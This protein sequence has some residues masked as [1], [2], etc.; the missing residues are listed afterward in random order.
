M[1]SGCWV[2]TDSSC[3]II[4]QQ[5]YNDRRLVFGCPAPVPGDSFP[6]VGSASANADKRGPRG[7]GKAFGGYICVSIILTC[8][9]NCQMFFIGLHV[10]GHC[11]TL[12]FI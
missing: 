6:P 3:V 5:I 11:Y 10:S 2:S 7:K 9:S 12:F 1:S 8:I 4:M